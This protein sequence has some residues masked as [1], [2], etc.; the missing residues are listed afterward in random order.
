MWCSSMRYMLYII[1]IML[2]FFSYRIAP[3]HVF[4]VALDDCFKATVYFLQ[5]AQHYNVDPEQIAV[6]GEY[7]K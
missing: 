4:P 2:I 5:N 6:C 1:I 7:N 3:E